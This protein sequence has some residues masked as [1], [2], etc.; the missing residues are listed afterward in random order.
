MGAEE[1]VVLSPIFIIGLSW[2]YVGIRDG[3]SL[4]LILGII[5]LA[6]GIYNLIKMINENIRD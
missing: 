6:I 3:S 2:A 1:C 5:C 4:A